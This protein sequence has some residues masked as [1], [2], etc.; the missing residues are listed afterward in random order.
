MK[1]VILWKV[2]SPDRLF[3]G[4]SWHTEEVQDGWRQVYSDAYEVEV[5]DDFY[6]EKS[7]SGE[8]LFFKTGCGHGYRLAIGSNC[9]NGNP[10]LVGGRPVKTIKLRVIKKVE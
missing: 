7:T 8:I 3:G 4:Y 9:E 6:I 2:Y 5:P 1:T 10:Y